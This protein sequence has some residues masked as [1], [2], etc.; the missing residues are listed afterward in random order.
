MTKELTAKEKMTVSMEGE[1]TRE[2]PVFVPAVD[3]YESDMGMT[4]LADMPGVTKE[5]LT[6]DIKDNTLSIR[7]II[8]SEDD[9]SRKSIYREYEEGDYY[10]QFALSEMI[11][12]SKIT[13]SLK[14]GV[15]NLFM[16]KIEP[17]QPRKIEI[18]AS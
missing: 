17:A 13:A 15:L 2:R 1:P 5:G 4:L 7:G 6:I 9:E 14:D 16:P 12:Q 10:R 11:D 18:S 3:I 8:K